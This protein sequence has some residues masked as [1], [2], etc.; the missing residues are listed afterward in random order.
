MNPHGGQRAEKNSRKGGCWC[1]S[2]SPKA[3]NKSSN[4]LGQETMG[5]PA[6]EERE[7]ALLPFCSTQVL[8]GL[9]DA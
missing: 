4:V 6:Q 8:K 9:D 7:F 2:R 5:V 1:K 3:I